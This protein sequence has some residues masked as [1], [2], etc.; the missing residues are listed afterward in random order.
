[1]KEA[2]TEDGRRVA[3]QIIS[4]GRV[5]FKEEPFDDNFFLCYNSDVSTI[6]LRSAVPEWESIG[7][8]MT[9]GSRK[10]DPLLYLWTCLGIPHAL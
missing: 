1:M 4:A 10:N 6:F 9:A 2:R 7:V 8:L 5:I 3:T